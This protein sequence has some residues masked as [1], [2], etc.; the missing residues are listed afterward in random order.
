[1][2]HTFVQRFEVNRIKTQGEIVHRHRRL[3]TS[4]LNMFGPHGPNIIIHFRRNRGFYGG[5]FKIGHN[6]QLLNESSIGN[7]LMT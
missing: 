2:L 4:K 5:H 7:L 6:D 3:K 1:M